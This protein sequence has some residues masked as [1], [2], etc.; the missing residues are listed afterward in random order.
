[1]NLV[2]QLFGFFAVVIWVFS[3]QRKDKKKILFTQMFATLL[4]TIQ[5]LLLSVFSAASMNFTS[6]LR[7]F[8]FYKYEEKNKEISRSILFVFVFLV[9]CLGIIFWDN[10]LSLIPIIITLFYTVSTWFKDAK[11]TRIFFL[12]VAFIWVY[13]NFVVGAYVCIIG[14]VLEIISGIVAFVRFRK[15][16]IKTVTY[17]EDNLS[18]LDI[19]DVVTRAK[20]LII[21]SSDNVLLGYCE[22]AYQFPGGHLEEG[23]DVEECVIREVL[24]ETGISLETGELKEIMVINHYTKNYRDSGRNRLNK[25]YYFLVKTDREP[26]LNNTNYVEREKLGGFTLEKVNLKDI[27]KVLNDNIDAN[28]INSLIVMEMLEVINEYR[29]LYEKL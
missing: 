27:D 24:E 14:N 7:S 6:C 1:M 3:I 16:N 10:Y 28:K 11:W 21:D 22:N 8:V 29:R 13:Y 17:N 18:D 2:A 9:I 20:C 5:Y 15:E 23:E 4:Y 12:I 25:I 19:D 26:D